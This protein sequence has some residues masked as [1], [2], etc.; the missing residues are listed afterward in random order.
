MAKGN[1]LLLHLKA[2]NKQLKAKMTESE[3]KIK[4]LEKTAKKSTKGMRSSLGGLK[5]GFAAVAV[6]ALA[7]TK[8]F[9]KVAEVTMVQVKAEAQLN[10][11]LKSTKNAAG[12][13]AKEVKKMAS[14]LQAVT[15]FGDETTIMGQNLLLTFTKIG[16]DVFPAA[17][18]IMLDMSA[19]MGT[20]LKSSA[21]QLGKALNDPVK[22][23]AALSR[24]GVQLSETQVDMIKGFVATGD[25]ASAQKVILGELQTQFGGVARALRES[26]TGWQALQNTLGDFYEDVGKLF[27]PSLRQ[28]VKAFQSVDTGGSG[29]LIGFLRQVSKAILSVATLIRLLDTWLS[30]ENKVQDLEKQMR[31]VEE[32][33]WKV[34]GYAEERNVSLEQYTQGLYRLHRQGKKVQDLINMGFGRI[35]LD[36]FG[37]WRDE[38]QK[39]ADAQQGVAD[40]YMSVSKVLEDYQNELDRINGKTKEYDKT[41]DKIRKKSPGGGPDKG[42][43]G[44]APPKPDLGQY[45]AY[46]GDRSGAELEAER[47]KYEKMKEMYKG[48]QE[49]LSA[50]DKAYAQKKEELEI[51]NFTNIAGQTLAITSDLASQIQNI[52]AMGYQNRMAHLNLELNARMN[53]L[54]EQYEAEVENLENSEMNDEER[55]AAREAIDKKYEREKK[56]LDAERAYRTALLQYEQAKSGKKI[57][58]VAALINTAQAVTKAL[59]SAFPPLNFMLA[60]LVGGLGAKQVQLIKA[61]PLPPKPEPPTYRTGHV[62]KF[63]S[64]YVPNDHSLAY[65]GSNEA[66]MTA[67]AT[68]QNAGLLRALNQ[69]PTAGQRTPDVNINISGNVMSDEFVAE[70]V[71]PRL[72]DVARRMGADLFS[73]DTLLK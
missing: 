1:E 48:H 38:T 27:I 70:S 73:E 34:K 42:P 5:A 45:L 61:Q 58:I 3:K 51:K 57:S 23:V 19:A 22:G 55:A 63:E 72:N 49:E 11:V 41:L 36:I 66:V 16:K 59:A 39:L 15:D 7:L 26:G 29:I 17:T 2:E 56:K 69:D 10:A 8:I 33:R 67:E 14:D 46:I 37:K 44:P 71:V 64:G 35:E 31:V 32:L 18:E 68:R 43:K 28:L 4:H 53:A 20:D 52:H 21:I 13:T 50:I 24:V 62:P 25:V 6:G 40:G 60:A 65:I 9:K 12:L 30:K 54:N 47:I